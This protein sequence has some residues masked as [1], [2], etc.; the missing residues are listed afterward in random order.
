MFDVI[1][2]FYYHFMDFMLENYLISGAFIGS[3]RFF[4][5]F[6]NANRLL[7]LSSAHR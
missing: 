3:K 7:A 6:V 5:I 1:L 4:R 2:L